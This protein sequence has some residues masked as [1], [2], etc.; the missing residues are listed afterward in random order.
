MLLA[1]RSSGQR[2]LVPAMI[3]GLVALGPHVTHGADI[4]FQPSD[5]FVCDTLAVDVQVD[6]SVS[7]L[8]GFSL[9]L[10]FDPTVVMPI[11][12]VA[13]PLV[14]GA[15]C[16]YFFQW[17]NVAAVGDSIWIDGA[18]LGCSVAGPGGIARITFVLADHGR[19]S[20]LGCL[21]GILRDGS[22]QT[23]PYVCHPATL[24]TCPAIGVESWPW[25]QVKRR[26]R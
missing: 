24:E 11:A 25:T 5:G 16:G 6:A 10:E 17:V 12:A 4:T 18:T 13:G 21:S 26:Y 23:I 1:I 20:P 14:T 19:T 9:V 8:R 3:V 7:D 2:F 15:G 22:N